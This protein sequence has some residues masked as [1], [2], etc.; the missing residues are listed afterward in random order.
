M[1]ILLLGSS[2]GY[3]TLD[4]SVWLVSSTSESQVTPEVFRFCERQHTQKPTK[5]W[6]ITWQMGKSIRF[7]W[8]PHLSL[9]EANRNFSPVLSYHLPQAE[10]KLH[11]PNLQ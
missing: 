3:S 2:R 5:Q 6:Q 8:F 9:P 4:G 11:V 10:V 7:R 1:E